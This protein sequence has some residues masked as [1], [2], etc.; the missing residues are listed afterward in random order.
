MRYLR[1]NPAFAAAII[2]TLGLAIGANTAI[3][4]VANAL[5]LKPLPYPDACG[6]RLITGHRADGSAQP[7]SWPR[8]R[9]LI[10]R[11]RSFVAIAGFTPDTFNLTGAGDPEQIAAARSPSAW[12]S[13]RAARPSSVSF[14]E[15]ACCCPRSAELSVRPS[16]RGARG[17]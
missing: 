4:T 6:L 16:A 5:L 2:L 3:F 13:A 10:E 9:T 15:K 17:R 14:S 7:L 12:P 8:T 11:D 1:R